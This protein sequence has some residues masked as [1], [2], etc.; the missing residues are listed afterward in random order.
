MKR[1]VYEQIENCLNHAIKDLR[2]ASD[3]TTIE[4]TAVEY[5]KGRIKA[6]EDALFEL[7]KTYYVYST[8]GLGRRYKR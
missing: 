8:F 4:G 3:L 2:K 6:A 7:R 1:N 5:N